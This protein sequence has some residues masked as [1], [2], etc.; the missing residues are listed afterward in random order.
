M[1]KP[2]DDMMIR[3]FSNMMCLSDHHG[4][5]NAAYIRAMS[6]DVFYLKVEVSTIFKG[7]KLCDELNNDRFSLISSANA[8]NAYQCVLKDHMGH[9]VEIV[10]PMH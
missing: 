10:R 9:F 4:E 7:L 8:T 6:Q 5:L 1:I 2:L 3:T